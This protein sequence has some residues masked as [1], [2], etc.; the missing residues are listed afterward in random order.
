MNSGRVWQPFE[1]GPLSSV[2]VVDG[3]YAD[4]EAV[5]RLAVSADYVRSP[6]AGYA[7]GESCR[8]Y[9]SRGH[10]ELFA[11]ILKR[12]VIVEPEQW[13]Y[14]KFRSAQT[15]EVGRY[16]V[17]LDT[18]AGWNAVI[19]IGENTYPWSGTTFFGLR[20]P[21]LERAPGDG[22]GLASLGCA[23]LR[24]FDARFVAPV[25]RCSSRWR[26]I[27]VVEARRNRCI[28]FPG[29]ELFHAAGPGYGSSLRSSRLTQNF[30]FR[31]AE[32]H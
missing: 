17:H 19:F 14:G 26:E 4:L 8:A 30:F 15:G 24:E 5:V 12:P 1:R 22:F 21:E 13:V 2:L 29:H 16:R 25:S 20:D 18:Q 31:V 23:S 7:G 27:G 11:S 28:I 9:W 10:A 32:G 6:E 3:F